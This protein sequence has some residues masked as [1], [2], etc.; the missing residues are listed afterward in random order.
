M[1]NRHQPAQLLAEINR[2]IVIT[3]PQ[4]TKKLQSLRTLKKELQERI[5]AAQPVPEE[6]VFYVSLPMNVR[7]LEAQGRAAVKR[8][9][10]WEQEIAPITRRLSILQSTKRSPE[11]QQEFLQITKRMTALQS[12]HQELERQVQA[13]KFWPTVATVAAPGT[14]GARWVRC[15][16]NERENVAWFLDSIG[17]SWQEVED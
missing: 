12:E 14:T 8:L 4:D 1:P 13:S 10:E 11:M 9:Q 7:N 3:N 2:E 17:A 16:W 6:A 5:Q 15:P